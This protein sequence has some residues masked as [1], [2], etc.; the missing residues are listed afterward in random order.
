[1]A[2]IAR[3]VVP[4][5]PHHITQRGNRRQ[6]TFFNKSDYEEYISLMRTFC[7]LHNI[8]IWAY[9]LM[10]NHV[11][12]IAVPKNQNSLAK[13]IGEAHRRYTRMVNFREG[14]RGHLWQ[15]RF[16]SFPL[17]EP[18]LLSATRYIE[19]N[20]VR[21]KLVESLFDWPWSSAKV[22]LLGIGDGLVDINPLSEMVGD[23]KLFLKEDI[24]DIKTF[25]KHE[26]TGRPLGNREFIDKCEVLLNRVLH[27]KKPGPKVS[28]RKEIE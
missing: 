5:L 19:M 27:P 17:D 7:R 2:R 15:G 22:H 20:P 8:K 13:A 1:M 11:H 6:K 12:L 9:C 18:Y 23:W 24:S 14:W 10:P 16:S 25:R 3:V 21:S 28:Q 4:N 26:H